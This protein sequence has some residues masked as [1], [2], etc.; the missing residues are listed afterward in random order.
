MSKPVPHD[1]ERPGESRTGPLAGADR[2]APFRAIYL[3]S[4]VLL[5]SWPYTVP[6]ATQQFLHLA[7]LLAIP[8]FLPDP[9]EIELEGHWCRDNLNPIRA[10]AKMLKQELD[11]LAL[12]WSCDPLPNDSQLLEAFRSLATLRKKEFSLLS[13]PLAPDPLST[14]FQSAVNNEYPFEAEGKNFQDAVILR[15]VLQHNVSAG[16]PPAAFVSKNKRDF[17]SGFT[18]FTTRFKAN[19]KYFG[20]E[21][22]LQQE[23]D[24]AVVTVLKEMWMKT[25]DAAELAVNSMLPD[26][27]A[28]L[29]ASFVKAGG[30]EVRVDRIY[31]VKTFLLDD[32]KQGRVP[33]S[34]SVDVS[35]ISENPAGRSIVIERTASITGHGALEKGSFSDISLEA[36]EFTR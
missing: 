2:H 31:D 5:P 32:S 20:T 23:L 17:Q 21:E 10:N 24:A 6:A 29:T 14:L 8:V 26:V 18:S 27:Q 34:F 33:I 19:V 7:S 4:N 1:R 25:Q 3:D 16:A 13:C 30:V 12:S 9:V 11:K 35:F 15:S 28:F 36:A 22:I